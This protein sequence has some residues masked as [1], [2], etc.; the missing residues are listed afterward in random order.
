MSSSRA[1]TIAASAA[2]LAGLAAVGVGAVAV[3]AP[4]THTTATVVATVHG[5]NHPLDAIPD[6][7]GRSIYFTTGGPDGPAVLRVGADGGPVTTVLRGRP[8][9]DPRGLAVSGDGSRLYVADRGAGRILVVSVHGG[10][11]HSLRGSVGTYPRGLV[12]TQTGGRQRVV[13]T[14]N[15]TGQSG[16]LSL[17][18]AGAARPTLITRGAPLS[19]PEGVAV[20]ATGTVYVTD[21]GT[22]APLD[23]RVFRVAGGHVT[24]VAGGLR[25]GDPAG[26]GLTSDGATLLV[27]SLNPAAGTAQVLEVDTAS[28][29]TSVFTAGIGENKAAG[30][31]HR[32]L[33]TTF[34]AWADVSRSGRVYRVDP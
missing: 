13:F 32:G 20:S 31:L 4:A 34:L 23:G 3:A 8:L 15:A 19:R 28:L 24:R 21:H 26:I 27:S 2:G 9:V 18:T 5:P 14:G 29:A 25:L 33:R 11:V 12:V 10:A 17:S 1:A 22:G 6:P 30:G 16:V 7:A